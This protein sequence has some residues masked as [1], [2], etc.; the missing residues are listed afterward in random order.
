MSLEVS[1]PKTETGIRIIP[2]LDS[3][4]DAFMMEYEE[5]KETGFN[6][7]IID[8][9]TGFIFQNRTG[10]ILNQRNINDAIRRIIADYNYDEQIRAKKEKRLPIMLP[11][12]SCHHLRHTF[13]TRLCE[14][15]SNPKVIM[16]IMGHKDIQTTM[17]IYAE[18][19]S[20]LKKQTKNNLSSEWNKILESDPRK[21]ENTDLILKKLNT[22]QEQLV[23][24]TS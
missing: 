5:Q 11:N 10:N 14:V 18:A 7:T 2:M 17:N 16:E 12:F 23:P 8:G 22:L 15:E 21:A 6:T 4:Y 3:V 24:C 19:Q 20:E 9:Y 1:T 13:C